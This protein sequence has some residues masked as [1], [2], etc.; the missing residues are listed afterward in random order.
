MAAHAGE[1]AEITGTFVCQVCNEA[2]RVP[3][4]GEIPRCPNGHDLFFD[5]RVDE[6]TGQKPVRTGSRA[7]RTG[8]R[9]RRKGAS[10]R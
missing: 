1:R 5:V 9:A 6:P 3:Q 4:G 7:R 8:S 2:V 10:A